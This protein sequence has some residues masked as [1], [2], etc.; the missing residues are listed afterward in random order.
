MAKILVIDLGTTY[1]KIALFDRSGRLCDVC[2]LAPPINAPKLGYM[3]LD[4]EA[5][6]KAIAEG[7]AQLRDL[8][9]DGLSDVDAVT[10]STQTN[11]FVLLDADSRP[12]TPIVLWLDRRADKLESEAMRRCEIPGFT[13][14]TGVP[15]VNHQ[16]MVAKLLWFQNKSPQTWQDT[17]KLC[18]ISDYLTL[19]L[20][21]RHVTE[22]GTAGL[23]G[24]LDIH[25]CRW[26]AEM[27]E[28]FEIDEH[29]LPEVARAG[30]ELGPIDP[31]VA[32]KF[33]L[34]TTCRFVVGC[35]DQ[36][37]GAIGVGNVE[38]GM[39]S[40]TT[41]T[42][43][44]TVRCTDRPADDLKANVFQGP[45]FVEGLYYRMVFSLVS[46]G[47]LQWYRNQ[48]P[49]RPD[50]EQLTTEAAKVEPGAGGLKLKTDVEPTDAGSIEEMFEG[51]TLRHTRGH[52][53]RCI[54][55]TVA[56]ALHDQVATIS[57]DSLPDE[58]RSAGGAARSDLWLKI[59]ADTIGVPVTATQCPEPTSLGV[60]IIAESSL[61]RED[62]AQVARRWVRLKP[63]AVGGR[64]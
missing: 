47:Y 53:V 20:T 4:T 35:L 55:E 27:L 33:G 44:A 8:N 60:A 28:R 5:F 51:M 34:P 29:C 46:A 37:A 1:F 30:T 63:A 49:D 6:T 58:I 13:A 31:N 2:R 23:T 25:S 21:G 18:L 41:G 48:L 52:A 43:L 22:A 45:A 9:G 38:P 42:A 17:R 24:L 15:Q 32:E 12:L 36:Y 64:W 3:E 40:E 7:I 19:L 11:S 54:M 50:F 14:T 61:G 16:F 59:K 10:F 39:I 26:W 57:G 56:G 62:I